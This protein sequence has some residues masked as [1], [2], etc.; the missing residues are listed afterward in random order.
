MDD[1]LFGDELYTLVFVDRD[2]LTQALGHPRDLE[3]TPP[4]WYFLSWASHFLADPNWSIRLPPLVFG[5][6]TVPVVWALG[7]RVAGARAGLLAAGLLAISPF[8]VYYSTEARVYAVSMF[9]VALALVALLVARPGERRWWVVLA[10]AIAGAAYSHYTALLPI[11]AGLAW[12]FFARAE[13]RRPLVLATV[14]AAAAYLPWLPF[15]SA[16]GAPDAIAALTDLSVGSVGREV[17]KLLPGQPYRPIGAVPGEVPLVILA[18][19]LLLAAALA[20]RGVGRPLGPGLRRAAAGPA[21]LVAAA[22]VAGPLGV[23]LYSVF[24]DEIFTGRN[25]S[26]SLPAIVVGISALLLAAARRLPRPAGAALLGLP[27]AAVVAGCVQGYGDDSRRP[28][29]NDAAASVEELARPGDAVVN[30]VLPPESILLGNDLRMLTLTTHL[31]PAVPVRAAP[32]E[33]RAIAAAAGDAG[34]AVVVIR[35]LPELPAPPP[36][37]LGGGFRVVESRTHPGLAPIAVYAYERG[38]PAGP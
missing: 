36:P 12:A 24:V 23:G 33:D 18:G 35:G 6:A 11:A 37:A 15:V 19:A 17:V 34:R 29:W 10:V 20:V 3:G 26:G 14:A 22:A 32:F 13:A 9:F 4:L 25:V 30:V 5:V 38:N 28:A 8:H 27:V 2:S 1:A 7:E 16:R 21:G 31:D